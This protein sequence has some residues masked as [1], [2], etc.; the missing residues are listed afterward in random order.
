MYLPSLSSATLLLTLPVDIL[1]YSSEKTWKWGLRFSCKKV[2]KHPPPLYHVLTQLKAV[3]GSTSA[4]P[5]EITS[6]RLITAHTLSYTR[7]QGDV[8]L[9]PYFWKLLV[10]CKMFPEVGGRKQGGL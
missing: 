5:P 10:S 9:Q 1:I 7:R 2:S 4:E 6:P 8:L 3:L